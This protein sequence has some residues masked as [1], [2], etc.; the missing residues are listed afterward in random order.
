MIRVIGYV[1]VSTDDQADSGESLAAQRAEIARYATDHKVAYECCDLFEDAGISGKST[2]NR[3]GFAQA[4]EQICTEAR[5]TTKECRLVV[6]SLSRLTRSV[7]DGLAIADRLRKDG[8]T[9]VSLS[10][11][12][13]LST[14]AGRLMFVIQLA[15]A[16]YKVEETAEQTAATI[17]SKK[18]KGERIG[19]LPIGVSL[20]TD[21]NVSKRG[22]PVT[23]A[24]STAEREV[25]DT[26]RQLAGQGLG[27]RPIASALLASGQLARNGK[28]YAESTIR[29]ILKR[30]KP[31]EPTKPE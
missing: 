19:A 16:Q 9:L 6:F 5:T 22:K 20:V 30:E 27:P 31:N 17:R 2:K 25:I 24:A 26:I 10:E 8:V 12:I 15:I 11:H 4:L 7:R 14:A 29:G 13:D 1:R 28:P 18:S 23:L 21:G 3:K